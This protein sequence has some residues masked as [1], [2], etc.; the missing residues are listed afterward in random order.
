LSQVRKSGYKVMVKAAVKAGG[1]KTQDEGFSLTLFRTLANSM[2][3]LVW[4]ADAKGQL[5]YFNERRSAYFGSSSSKSGAGWEPIVHPEDLEATIGAWFQAQKF[6]DNYEMEH[7][8]RM[9]DGTYL[10]HI[11]RAFPMKAG[12]GAILA[13]FGTATDIDRLK[14]SEAELQAAEERLRLATQAADM[15]A[16]EVDLKTGEM[17]WA[18]NAADIIGCPTDMLSNRPESGNFFVAPRD[19]ERLTH[20]FNKALSAGSSVFS[21]QFSGVPKDGET[22]HWRAFGKFLRSRDGKPVR[23]VGITQNVS[24]QK[25]SDAALEAFADRLAAAEDGAGALVYD[26]DVKT[27]IVWRSGGMTRLLGWEQGEIAPTA[28]A[29]ANIMHPDD[30][31]RLHEMSEETAFSPSGHSVNEYRVQHKDGRYIWVL[32]SGRVFRD[33]RGKI[34][35]IAG[36]T[37]DITMKR[38]AEE[39]QRR[40]ASLVDLSFEPI[41]VWHAE[42]GIQE[43]NKG[44]EHLYGYTREEA[45]G[46]RTHELLGTNHPQG[47]NQFLM[48][49]K[50]DKNWSGEL[51]HRAKDGRPITVESRHQLIET[52]DDEFILETNRDVAERKKA[53]AQMARLAAVAAASHDALFG[54]NLEGVI[55]A[56]NPGA[57]ALLGYTEAEALGMRHAKLVL[58]SRKKEQ[59]DIFAK[60]QAGQTVPPS[61]TQL[62]HKNGHFVNVSRAMTPVMSRDGTVIGISIAAHDIGDR[63]EWEERQMLM[64]RELAHRVK[65]SFAVLQAIL[66]STLKSS[67]DPAQ[68]AQAFSGRLQSLSAAHDVLSANDWRGA[69]LGALLRHQLSVY[70]SGQR[71]IL[72]GAPVNLTAEY[73]APVSLIVNELATNALKYGALSVPHG[74]IAVSW[75]V[76]D[77]DKNASMLNL[78]WREQGGPPAS[79]PQH[80]GFGTTLIQ[81]SLAEAQVDVEYLAEGLVCRVSWPLQPVSVARRCT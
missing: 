57:E 66:R 39:S 60:V 5:T 28:E 80:H 23:A 7:R 42:H 34:V 30:Q 75:R 58:P 72:T 4:I 74:I 43:W 62:L 68:F 27:G 2:P 22:T 35:R 25:K 18:S 1:E 71:I 78:E 56:W 15:F 40:T 53:D 79:Q 6:I 50:R 10:W 76:D 36:T 54:A 45:L 17:K 13:W 44:A 38:K 81:R 32:D 61:D 24:M 67:P 9:A 70:L 47:L 49:L 12:E 21:L 64:N 77:G 52:G 26:W 73:T 46:R 16:W 33:N 3:Q 31:G 51:L 59:Q 69:E 63:L 65:N 20:E 8:L 55:E 29:W 14:R 48:Q 41:F 11:S 19:R 37:I